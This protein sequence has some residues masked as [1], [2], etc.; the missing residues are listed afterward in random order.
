MKFR[1]KFITLMISYKKISDGRVS[2]A[3]LVLVLF[4]DKHNLHGA[5]AAAGIVKIDEIHKAEFS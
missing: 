1:H 2:I 5:G 3:C 4:P